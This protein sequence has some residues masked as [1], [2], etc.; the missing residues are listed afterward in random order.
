MQQ[1]GAHELIDGEYSTAKVGEEG[2]QTAVD[3]KEGSGFDK[4]DAL[5][6]SNVSEGV[7]SKP[8]NK[9]KD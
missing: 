5:N 8:N 3:V 9:A 1:G 4:A 6:Q 7:F 2:D